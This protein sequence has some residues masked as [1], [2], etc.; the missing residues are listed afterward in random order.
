MKKIISRTISLVL[1]MLIF[2]SVICVSAESYITLYAEDGRSKAFPA[3]QVEA[4][5]TV[6][7]YRTPVQRLYAEG[8]SKVFKKAEVEAQLTVGWYTEPVQ[9]LYAPGKSKLFKKSQVA[10]QLTVGWHLEEFVMMYAADGRTKYVKKSEVAANKSVGWY[11]SLEE[12]TLAQNA[13]KAKS[14]K[15]S[16]AQTGSVTGLITYQYN[17]YVGTRAD[18]G[19][20][21]MLVQ[22]NHIPLESDSSNFLLA[23][24]YDDPLIYSTTVDGS[25]NYYFDSI[26][27]GEYYLLVIGKNTNESPSITNLNIS[28]AKLYLNG[29]ITNKAMEHLILNIKLYSF[30]IEKIK[31]EG[32][33]T[34]RYNKDWGY[35]YI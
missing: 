4:Q 9:R 26:P 18:V 34:V 27:T 10:A 5:L 22:T 17:K 16:S 14:L 8:K 31:I 29:K 33:K 23:S 12:I 11:E 35:T 24:S 13:Q 30:E 1:C 28:S 19:A 15:Y 21:V 32:G 6:G 2:M 7:W 3:S 25:G 20:K